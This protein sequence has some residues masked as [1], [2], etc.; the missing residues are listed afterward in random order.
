MRKIVFLGNSL[1]AKRKNSTTPSWAEKFAASVNLDH[2]NFAVAAGNN[3]TQALLLQNYLLSDNYHPDDIFFW[4]I[5]ATNRKNTI[6]NSSI[7][8]DTELSL[9]IK[10][11]LN[12]KNTDP[13]D[14]YFIELPNVFDPDNNLKMLLC[15]FP[16]NTIEH[17][18]IDPYGFQSIDE[19]VLQ[20][21]VFYINLLSQ[22]GHNV[23]FTLGWEGCVAEKH[24]STL[25]R[26]LNKERIK[27]IENDMLGWCVKQNIPLEDDMH[28]TQESTLRWAR[29]HLTPLVQEIIKEDK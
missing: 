6:V 24:K 25:L 23:I 29:V 26:L 8:I 10:N 2:Q 20:E 18:L 17:K 15:H 12:N 11:Y 16:T 9:P 13:N 21:T 19:V 28:P 1:T 5:N 7:C 27:Y 3:R 22:L 14:Y 4:E